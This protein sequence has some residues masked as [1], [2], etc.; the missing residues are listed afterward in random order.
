IVI[1]TLTSVVSELEG[2][3]WWALFWYAVSLFITSAICTAFVERSADEEG[4]RIVR[5]FYWYST[6]FGSSRLVFSILFLFA[7]LS[8]FD[9]Q[10]KQTITLIGFWGFYMAL[11]PL[12]IPQIVHSLFAKLQKPAT[13]FEGRI[14]R[15][16]SP[17][18][19]RVQ[20]DPDIIW[21]G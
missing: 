15:T 20:L 4:G 6:A 9:L 14:L 5:A 10:S 17:G 8:F 16:D 1:V 19:I 21:K 2:I 7:V 11:W 3:L 13:S 18:L 12:R